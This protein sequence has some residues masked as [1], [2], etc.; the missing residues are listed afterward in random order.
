MGGG[1]LF[2]LNLINIHNKLSIYQNAKKE[3]E[4]KL[5]LFQTQYLFYPVLYFYG[6]GNGILYK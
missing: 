1:D 6:F 5:K 4:E 2:S 3:L